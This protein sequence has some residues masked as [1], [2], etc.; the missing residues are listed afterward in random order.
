M[1]VSLD[2]IHFRLPLNPR[3]KSVK[4]T[5]RQVKT[6][7]YISDPFPPRHSALG[8]AAF[9]GK[10]FVLVLLHDPPNPFPSTP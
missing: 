3:E 4:R 7:P 6:N 10:I 2:I 9:P 1:T 8:W 5:I